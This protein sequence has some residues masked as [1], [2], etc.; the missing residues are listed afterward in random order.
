VIEDVIRM[1]QSSHARTEALAVFRRPR[2][3]LP[4]APTLE[5]V[6]RAWR[7][8]DLLL[9]E[10]GRLWAV[11]RVTRATPPKDFSSDKTIAGEERREL[12]RAAA[13]GR[14]EPGD[15]VNVG[16]S[17]VNPEAPDAMGP[18]AMVDGVPHVRTGPRASRPLEAYLRE[19]AELLIDAARDPNTR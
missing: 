15:V 14:F 6:G 5:P 17:A 7:L 2:R 11:D 12:Q 19:R 9:S 3:I 16:F 1:L 13:Q 10:D 8:G 18:L 4:S